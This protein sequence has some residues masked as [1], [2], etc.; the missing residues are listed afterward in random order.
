[1]TGKGDWMTVSEVAEELKLPQTR[2]YKLIRTSESPLPAHRV[3]HR[4]IRI[5]RDELQ[6]WL[7]ERKIVSREE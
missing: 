4:T 1:M 2:V 7:D 3:G 6:R 5:R